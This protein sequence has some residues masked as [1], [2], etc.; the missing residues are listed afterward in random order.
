M[1]EQ[2]PLLGLLG[3]PG[4]RCLRSLA[5]AF[6]GKAAVAA[7][8]ARTEGECREPRERR[9]WEAGPAGEQ[10]P[11][12]RAVSKSRVR[13]EPPE[14][15]GTR[16]RAR[17]QNLGVQGLAGDPAAERG[18]VRRAL[19]ADGAKWAGARSFPSVEDGSGCALFLARLTSKA[20]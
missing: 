12:E 8:G 2:P 16:G 3:L 11:A 7:V 6:L 9:C 5:P 4:L 17:R 1:S 10:A 18:R 13:A 19:W 15:L 14:P 20:P